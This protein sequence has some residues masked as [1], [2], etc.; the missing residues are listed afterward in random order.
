MRAACLGARAAALPSL[1]GG[2]DAAGQ[3]ARAARPGCGRTAPMPFSDRRGNEVAI[4]IT[5]VGNIDG[6]D[7]VHAAVPS[8]YTVRGQLYRL[9]ACTVTGKV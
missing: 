1:V 6:P 3:G 2:I 7:R 8:Q 5:A 4:P 9:A